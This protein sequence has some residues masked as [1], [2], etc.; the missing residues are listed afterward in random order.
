MLITREDTCEGARCF[1]G[2]HSD[3]LGMRVAVLV[4]LSWVALFSAKVSDLFELGIPEEG[5]LHHGV[6]RRMFSTAGAGR[7]WRR[8][9]KTIGSSVQCGSGNLTVNWI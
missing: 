8:R 6:G 9:S 1:T 3:A 2:R 7:S 5:R 4:V